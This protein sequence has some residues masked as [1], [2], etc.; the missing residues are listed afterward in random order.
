VLKALGATDRDVRRLFFAEAGALGLFGG[1]FGGLG[2]ADWASADLGQEDL[3]AAAG[4]ARVE[5]FI[6]TVVVGA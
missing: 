2:V 6:C 3:P 5:N 1:I 4:F